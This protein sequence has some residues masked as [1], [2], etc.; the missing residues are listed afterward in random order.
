MGKDYAQPPELMNGILSPSSPK[1]MS[2]KK[3][4]PLELH[5]P[6][7]EPQSWTSS[8]PKSVCQTEKV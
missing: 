2:L 7:L 5:E 8:C 3:T 6:G 1:G 4:W